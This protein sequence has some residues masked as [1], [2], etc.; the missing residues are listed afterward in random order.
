M[1]I[2][3]QDLTTIAG[4]ITL[5]NGREVEVEVDG[6]FTSFNDQFIEEAKT[7]VTFI[8]RSGNWYCPFDQIIILNELG[9]GT[10]SLTEGD[11]WDSYGDVVLPIKVQVSVP[12]TA[13]ILLKKRIGIL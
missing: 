9:E 4:I 12:L 1:Q 7:V 10:I 13:E 11:A 6:T 2:T 3:A 5:L 8:S